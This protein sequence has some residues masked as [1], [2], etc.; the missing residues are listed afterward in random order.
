M[1]TTQD[2]LQFF[3]QRF[4]LETNKATKAKAA[5]HKKIFIKILHN[6]TGLQSTLHFVL[7][8]KAKY[9]A[10]TKQNLAESAL[11]NTNI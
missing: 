9:K 7:C 11:C 8:K 1:Q 3:L 2:L 4:V 6:Q 10:H 5:L